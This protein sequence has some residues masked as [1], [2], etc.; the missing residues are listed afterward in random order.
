M[1]PIDDSAHKK[2]I[3]D[4][5]DRAAGGFAERTKSRFDEVDIAGFSQV[6]PEATVLEVGAGTGNFLA[7][8]KGVSA[9]RIALDL[10]LGMLHEA[11]ERHQGLDLVQGDAFTLP[12][13]SGSIDLAASAQALHHIWKP[14]PVLRE[15]RRVAG[16]EGK[17]LIVDQLATERFEEVAFMNEL[18]T[19]RDPSHATSRPV[20][21]FHVLVNKAGLEIV[22]Q[23]IHED[24]SR[25]SAW[26]WTGEFPQTRI[27]A[28]R[29]FIDKFGAETGMGFEREG[30][31]WSFTRRRIMILARRA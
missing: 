3:A 14:V 20:S 31:D 13:R 27:D 5:F 9:R 23:K 25:F 16:Q 12:F 19:I 22:D 26:M 4:E 10:T 15:L 8:F 11:K 6:S 24:R 28:T 30:E 17:V 2:S 1:R 18:E 21:A 29:A 7:H